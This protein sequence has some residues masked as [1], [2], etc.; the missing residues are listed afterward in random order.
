MQL[1]Q[2]REFCFLRKYLSTIAVLRTFISD[3]EWRL[4][5]K[6]EILN[7]A[8]IHLQVDESRN[9][10]YG[11]RNLEIS[12]SKTSRPIISRISFGC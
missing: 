12:Y 7:M 3:W 5:L 1:E 2:F 4:K 10:S 11:C 8:L 6:L 9:R